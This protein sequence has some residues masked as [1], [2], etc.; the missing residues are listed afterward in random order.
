[1]EVT[2]IP[3]FALYDFWIIG[4]MVFWTVIYI[5]RAVTEENHLLADE[6]YVAYCSQVKWRFIPNIF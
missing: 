1:M 3:A 6:D 4:T 5:L 2:L